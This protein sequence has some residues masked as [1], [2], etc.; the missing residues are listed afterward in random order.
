[1]FGL[2]SMLWNRYLP[3]CLFNYKIRHLIDFLFWEKS[4]KQK[5]MTRKN[6]IV[7]LHG[8]L[9]TVFFVESNCF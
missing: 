8:N 9:T 7:V 5:K 4:K 3:K 1:M 6:T 2:R